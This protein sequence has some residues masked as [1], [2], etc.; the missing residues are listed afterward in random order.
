MLHTSVSASA[1]T[2]LERNGSIVQDTPSSAET[3]K[4][5]QHRVLIVSD[6]LGNAGMERQLA[7]LAKSLP[8]SWSVRVVGLSDGVYAGVLREAGLDVTVLPR[9][10]RFDI[11]PAVPLGKIIRDWR[12][13]V[14]HTYG[15]IS[16]AA[17]LRAC[18]LTGIP[19]VD[20]SI[21]DGAVPVRRGRAMRMMTSRADVVIANSQAGLDAFGIDPERGRVVR[22]GFDPDRWAL[23]GHGQHPAA[24]PMVVVMTARMDP[25]KD[26][27]CL[28]DAARILGAEDSEGWRF[29]AVGSGRNHD[30]LLS[31]YHD[32][33]DS[34]VVT[35]PGATNEVLSLVRGANVGVLLTDTAFHAEGIPNSVMEYMACGLPVICTDSGGNR[36]L[37]IEGETGFLV[38]S[39]DVEA[40][41]RQLR[42]LRDEPEMASRMG[43]AGRERIA[44]EFTVEALVNGTVAA[45]ELARQRRRTV[46]TANETA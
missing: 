8:N 17:S 15:W 23:C 40:V 11:R 33:L 25:H 21:Q 5:E 31:E 1:P 42:L 7:L 45:Y 19:L 39:G 44:S 30:E 28:L 18:R 2:R 10:F 46:M 22:N 27:R 24:G 32:L 3:T 9:A 35:F 29:L 16:T 41:V 12:P 6:S 4:T 38:P 36:E 14:V 43:R 37:V 34:G 20:A 13:T 26:Y